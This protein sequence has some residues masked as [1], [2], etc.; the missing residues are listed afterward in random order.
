[1][2]DHSG[3]AAILLSRK[4]EVIELIKQYNP[5]YYILG[6]EKAKGVHALTN[7]EHFHMVYAMEDH[8][9]GAFNTQLK[10]KF[11][12]GSKNQPDKAY[13]GFVS[14]INKVKETKSYCL[15]MVIIYQKD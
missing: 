15:K 2:K 7:G 8:D 3:V 10:R 14:Q 4:D 12:L 9:H 6:L 13:C 5:K 1:M 11:N